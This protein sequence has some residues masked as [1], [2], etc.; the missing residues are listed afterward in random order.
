M[1]KFQTDTVND[2]QILKFEIVE[3][4]MEPCELNSI[5]IPELDQTKG[6]VISGRGPIWLYAFLTHALHPHPWLA[7]YDPRLGGAV[8][9]ERHRKEAPEIGKIIKIQPL[10]R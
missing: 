10:L 6:V 5:E 1:I 7:T 2:Y 8:V 9:I 4:V 3:G